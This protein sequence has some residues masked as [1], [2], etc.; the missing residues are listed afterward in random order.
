MTADALCGEAPPVAGPAAGASSADA[1]T[2]EAFA[3]PVS[4]LRAEG[5]A[6]R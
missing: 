3:A 4:G 5:P 2:L 6:V 1:G